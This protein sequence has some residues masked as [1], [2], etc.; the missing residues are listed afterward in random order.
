MPEHKTEDRGGH[1]RTTVNL[2]CGDR[3]ALCRCFKSLE[4]PF[5]DGAHRMLD[6]NVGPVIVEVRREE[7]KPEQQQ[8]AP[9]K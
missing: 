2:K 4:F 7:A 1:L 5:C 9:A 6:S 3:T 8:E